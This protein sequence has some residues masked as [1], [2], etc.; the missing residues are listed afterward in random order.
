MSEVEKNYDPYFVR[1]N[2]FLQ[3]IADKCLR[4]VFVNCLNIVEMKWG[5]HFDGYEEVRANILRTGNDA[6]RDLCKT[7][8]EDFNIES[9]P[10][11]LTVH[12][13]PTG[14]EGQ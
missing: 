5:K 12:F 4:K 2:R 14:K 6:V 1:S 3:Q 11:K 7:I 10:S 8:E 13:K 9:I